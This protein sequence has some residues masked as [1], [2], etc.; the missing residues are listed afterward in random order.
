MTRCPACSGVLTPQGCLCTGSEKR[1]AERARGLLAA[2]PSATCDWHATEDDPLCGAPVVR[3][4][5]DA[6]HGYGVCAEHMKFAASAQLAHEDD[7][8]PP[9]FAPCPAC[10]T[11]KT[12]GMDCLHCGATARAAEYAA[13]PQ[14][15]RKPP[16]RGIDALGILLRM[17]PV[18]PDE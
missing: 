13:I 5:Y 15:S 14:R 9:R 12:V 8:P 2:A 6:G 4:I 7:A 1:L 18:G 17:S 10:G 16:M 3:V 11:S